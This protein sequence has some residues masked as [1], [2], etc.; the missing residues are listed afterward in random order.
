MTRGQALIA[1]IR[2][3][4]ERRLR[5]RDAA[6]ETALCD[7]AREVQE[8]ST[9]MDKEIPAMVAE[10]SLPDFEAGDPE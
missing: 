4:A 1:V 6:G 5:E 3:I 10:G 2:E 9:A 8:E 7:D